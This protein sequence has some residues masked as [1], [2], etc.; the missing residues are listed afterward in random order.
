MQAIAKTEP[1][2]NDPAEDESEFLLACL[3]TATLRAKLIANELDSVGVALRHNF[4]SHDGAI[5]WLRDLD[6]AAMRSRRPTVSCH[7]GRNGC[8][9]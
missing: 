7:M 2:R 1:L 6:L 9:A 4:V 5:D 3:R 8:R